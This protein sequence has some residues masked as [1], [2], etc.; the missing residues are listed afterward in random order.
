MLT[1]IDGI[2]Y[3]SDYGYSNEYIFKTFRDDIK[4]FDIEDI[5]LVQL[6]EPGRRWFFKD[7]PTVGNYHVITYMTNDKFFTKERKKA[8]KDYVTYLYNE[9]ADMIL[10]QQTF[11]ALLSILSSAKVK[12]FKILPGFVK[13]PGVIGSMSDISHNEFVNEQEMEKWYKTHK[14]D[15]RQN[16]LSE[17]NH[18]IF[19]N[20][21]FEWIKNPHI[22]LNLK[23][24]FKQ[25]FLKT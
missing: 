3:R 24:D 2:E 18:T 19:A 5:V 17:E 23:Q 7:H 1:N 8:I 20:K 11:Y 9:D 15:I 16:H 14:V 4:N 13:C 12:M 21:I 6:T 22:E 25:G 10:Y